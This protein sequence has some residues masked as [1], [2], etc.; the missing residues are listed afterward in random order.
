MEYEHIVLE[1]SA[2]KVFSIIGCLTELEKNIDITKIKAFAG[3]SSGAIIAF[4]LCIGIYP[5]EISKLFDNIDTNNLLKQNIFEGVKEFVNNYGYYNFNNFEIILKDILKKKIGKEDITFK[6]IYEKYNKVLVITGTCINKR[7]THYYHYQSN[8]NMSIL[9]ALRISTCIPFVFGHIKWEKDLLVD[10][11]L[12]DNYPLWFFTNGLDKLPNSKVE[13]LL[14]PR[15][16]INVK[17]LGIK[18]LE[19][20][21]DSNSDL[22]NKEQS[23]IINNIKDYSLE[24]INTMMTQIERRDIISNYWDQTISIQLPRQGLILNID[25]ETK[26]KLKNIGKTSAIS[27]I[28]KK[29]EVL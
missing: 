25:K 12:L 8:P 17:T 21:E 13:D 5:K 9:F 6:E 2:S 24:I 15:D 16:S 14:G 3:T 11:C 27:F 28:K 23:I 10:G 26:E 20:P 7:R 18:I 19:C 29:K 22:F 4:L 1:G